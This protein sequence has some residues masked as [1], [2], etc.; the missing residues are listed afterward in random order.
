MSYYLLPRKQ[1][2][3]T[4][5]PIYSS[6]SFQ[7]SYISHSLIHYI[8]KAKEQIDLL[9]TIYDVENAEI[10]VDTIYKIINPYEFVYSIVPGS[11]FSVSKIKTNASIFYTL[12]E[13]I[14]LF[15]IFDAYNKNINLLYCSSN[16]N[17]VIDCVNIFRE[18]YNDANY[19]D[20][21]DKDEFIPI[22]GL[23]DSAVDFLYIEINNIGINNYILNFI[24]ALCYML[25]Y[26]NECGTCVMRVESLHYKP[27][28][29]VVYFLTSMYEKVY[30]IKPNISNSLNDERFIICKNFLLDHSRMKEAST[31]IKT[32]ND[33]IIDIKNGK[34]I[35]SIIN[36][37]LP[38]YFLN[39][40]EESNIII[41][42][43]QLEHLDQVINTIKNK[44]RDNKIE[45]LKKNNIQKSIQWCEKNKI[46]YN[47]FVDKLNI[48]LPLSLHDNSPHF[49]ENSE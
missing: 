4:V 10:N 16:N 6:E 29:D 11:K 19:Q 1:C 44:N 36:S 40:L 46:P 7:P 30:I 38:Y 37:E 27:V 48:F 23:D 8:K 17:V 22:I 9:M 41:G 21:F 34:N 35:I 14:N 26:Q 33:I 49:Y 24:N 20:N 18:N 42:Q 47:K 39:K 28:L 32:L 13:I 2:L 3:S 31:F 45:T 15:N 25:K 12:M 5:N 43:L